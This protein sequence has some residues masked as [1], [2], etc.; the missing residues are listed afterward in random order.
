MVKFFNVKFNVTML[1]VMIF[2]DILDLIFYPG[3]CNICD[4]FF[5]ILQLSVSVSQQYGQKYSKINA[6]QSSK[7]QIR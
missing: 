3:E 4:R 6:H 2:M 5:P 1:F 7:L